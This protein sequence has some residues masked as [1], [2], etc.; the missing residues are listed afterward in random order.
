LAHRFDFSPGEI[1][2]IQRK[3]IIEKALGNTAKR[4]DLILSLA[5]NEK[6]QSSPRNGQKAMGF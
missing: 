2:N 3:Y 4:F 5:G 6:I 1:S